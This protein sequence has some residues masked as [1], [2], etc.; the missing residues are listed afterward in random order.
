MFPS[1]LR[2]AHKKNSLNVDTFLYSNLGLNSWSVFVK[3]DSVNERH[4][5]S[6]SVIERQVYYSDNWQRMLLYKASLHTKTKIIF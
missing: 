5:T 2:A 4:I 6:F 3:R 1:L